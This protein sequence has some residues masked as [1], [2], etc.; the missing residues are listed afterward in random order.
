MRAPAFL[1]AFVLAAMPAHADTVIR[2]HPG[3]NPFE[4]YEEFLNTPGRFIVDGNCFSACTLVVATGRAC[5]TPRGEFFVH[6]ARSVK[7]HK[8]SR[9]ATG[10]MFSL[11]PPRMQHLLGSLDALMR[12][13]E[14]AFRVVRALD[15]LPPCQ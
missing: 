11:Y 5:A 13:P 1:L 12:L 10:F 7:T 3:G 2:D 14:G 9:L 15:V 4:L 8:P 6:Q